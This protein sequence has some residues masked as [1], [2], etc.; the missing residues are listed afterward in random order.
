MSARQGESTI[1]ENR[2]RIVG[3]S[4]RPGKLVVCSRKVPT[5]QPHD[6]RYESETT[7]ERSHYLV[8]DDLHIAPVPTPNDRGLIARDH[9]GGGVAKL[10]HLWREP[11]QSADHIEV[12]PPPHRA[13]RSHD[14]DEL[15]IAGFAQLIPAES[16][17]IV[18]GDD[19]FIQ[20]VEKDCLNLI[21]SQSVDW[22]YVDNFCFR[23]VV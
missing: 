13:W 8:T 5:S 16:I 15:E 18:S 11:L 4:Q 23:D 22:L 1:H 21:D 19:D 3:D 7:D 17:H 9:R 10:E 6:D 12:N 2:P 20:L 14:A